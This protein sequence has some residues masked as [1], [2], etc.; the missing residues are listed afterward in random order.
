MVNMEIQ[1]SHY[2]LI[3]SKCYMHIFGTTQYFK[4]LD[5]NNVLV[6]ICAC[7]IMLI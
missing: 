4:V 6:F 3:F 7:I 1:I 5:D 2:S